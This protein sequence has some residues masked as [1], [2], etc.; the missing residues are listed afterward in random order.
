MINLSQLNQLQIILFA[1]VFLRCSSFFVS[2]ALFSASGINIHFKILF[3]LVLSM[4]LFPTLALQGSNL[5]PLNFDTVNENLLLLVIREVFVGLAIGLIS[6]FFFFAVSMIGDLISMALGLGASQL[7]NPISG[8]QSQL[9]DQFFTWLSLMIFL[10]LGGHHILINALSSSFELIP[11]A[12]N[13][14]SSGP[15]AAVVTDYFQLLIIAIQVSAPVLI[16]MALTNLAMGILGRT[17][18][19]I[20]VL[21]TSFPISIL[22]GLGVLILSI[23]MWTEEM[24]HL[25]DLTSTELLKFMKAI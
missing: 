1:L 15:L 3:A 5:N 22:L 10:S 18:P 13:K 8:T 4:V 14:F 23:P 24:S 11:L 9:M 19:Q 7:F 17:V 21:V 20:N 16:S 2:A 6:R 25:L 12:Q